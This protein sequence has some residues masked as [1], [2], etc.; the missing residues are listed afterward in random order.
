MN[1]KTTI[2]LIILAGGAG[3]LVWK[4]GELAPKVGLAP[5]PTPAAKG[6][7]VG[8]L[9]GLTPEQVTAITVRAPGSAPVEF[10]SAGTGKPLEL[11]GNWPVRRNEVAE[12]VATVTGLKSRFQPVPLDPN[13]DLK[14]YGLAKSQDPVIVEVGTASGK[15]TLTVGEAP[16]QPGENPFTRPAFVRVDQQPEVL[17]L[18]PDVLPV[19]RRPA[20]FYRKR[21]LFPDQ[22]RLKVADSSRMAQDATPA[23]FLNDAVTSITVEGP[24]GKYVLRRTGPSP[25]AQ[26]PAD[27]PG[28]EAVV[29]VS[30]LADAWEIAEPLRD[31]ADPARL[32]AIL[33]AIPE[34]WVEQFLVNP[35]P[36]AALGSVL[37]IG[38]GETPLSGIARTAL[39]ATILTEYAQDGPFLDRSGFKD[40]PSKLTL[41]LKDGSTRS[42]LIGKTTRTSTRLET[43][44]PPPFPMAPQPPPR[45]VEEKFYHAKLADNPSV[46]EIKGDKLAD[47]LIEAAK[48]EG[49]KL[50]A[51]A[52]AFQQLR[53]PNLARFESDSV[54]SVRV[55]RPG[56]TLELKKTKGDPKAE[57][58]AGRKDRWDLAAPFTGLAESRQI[59]DLLDPL[60]RLAAQKGQVIDRPVLHLVTG[61]LGVADLAV[62]GLTPDQ[63]TVVPITS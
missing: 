41:T 45:M 7:S 51:P 40:K 25:K 27:K 57:S 24:Q 32:K 12:L 22:E 44:P 48:A 14:Q 4:G 63:A 8:A 19:L 52:P 17:R 34:L 3:V 43:P 10:K 37:P 11:P 9:A 1:L 30:R 21:Q 49:P 46:F 36:L 28:G 58:E 29:L 31:R 50:D 20:D 33:A 35:D 62:A 2:A 23:F 55:T 15:H 56:Q 54:A 47:L 38:V 5:E 16:A 39:G 13:D 18:G 60:E 59:T 53:D 6:E 42:L 61:G 26:P